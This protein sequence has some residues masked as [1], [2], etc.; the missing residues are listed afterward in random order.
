MTHNLT[1]KLSIPDFFGEMFIRLCLQ[2]KK[3]LY[4]LH[5][6]SAES[7]LGVVLWILPLHP[8]C[9]NMFQRTPAGAG[10]ECGQKALV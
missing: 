3:L 7:A 8:S 9:C 6:S 4:I 5:K 2:G 1:Q 10:G